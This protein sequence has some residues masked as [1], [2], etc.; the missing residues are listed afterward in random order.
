MVKEITTLAID[1]SCDETSVAVIKGTT[2]LS[3]VL[4]SQMGFHKK[5]GGVVP[6]LAKLAHQQRIDKVVVES[7]K[8]ANV[9][10]DKIDTIAVTI[11]PGLAMALEIGIQKAKDLA[12]KY[13]KPIVTVNHM[14][15][16]LLSSF[17]ESKVLQNSHNR[18]PI[19]SEFPAIGFL[20]S[21]GH[22]E[23]ILVKTFGDYIKIGETLD[24]S[25]GEAYDKC[26]RMLGLG[27]PAGPVIS[28]FAKK[29][30]ENMNIEVIRRNQSTLVKGTNINSKITYE[31][32]IAMANSGDLNFSYSGV[33]TAFRLIVNELNGKVVSHQDEVNQE[34]KLSKDQIYDLCVVFE[35]AALKQLELKLEL[36]IEKYSP[37]EVWLGGGVVASAR[38]RNVLRNICR[39][40]GISMRYPHSKKLTGDNAAMIG[41]AA[42]IKIQ[43]IGGIKNVRHDPL[44]NLYLKDFE[45]I[46]RIPSLSL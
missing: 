41:V 22:T 2:I 4:P 5:Y 33:K 7:M 10:F 23:L 45:L 35:A 9:D 32:P 36:A 18:N 14:E 24:D 27:Y 30:R 21:G 20:I 16:H 19:K 11:G 42:N 13:N 44:N 6:N 8:R 46:D 39:K 28:E 3:N 1:T 26:G 43:M 29:N 25:C 15:G 37:K 31:L 38:L 17:A 40:Y 34:I 12:E